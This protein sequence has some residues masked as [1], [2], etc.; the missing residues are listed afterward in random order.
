MMETIGY[1]K[2][3]EERQSNDYYATPP[4][5]IKNILKHEDL[6]GTILENSCGQ[7]HIAKVVKEQYPDNEVIAT[8]LIDRGY[9]ENGLDFLSDDYPYTDVDT[10]I[11]NPPF[12][13]IE[14]FVN[15]SLDIADKV[16]LFARL[17]FLESQ[18]RYENIFV[19]N[20]PNR[21][22]IYVDR[23]SCGKNGNFEEDKNSM[24]YAWFVWDGSEE[25]SF[26][27]I[28]KWNKARQK[29]LF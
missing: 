25:H 4:G 13:H 17:Q 29:K 23:V 14:G 19:D 16:L 2:N 26:E 11:M 9:G 28:R 5:E 10:V 7:G 27:W 1:D 6:Q 21:V 24:S 3:H 12:K 18:S 22:Y 20:E 15:K 8:D